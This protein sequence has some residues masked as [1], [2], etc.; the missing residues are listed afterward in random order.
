MEHRWGY[1]GEGDKKGEGLS[2]QTRKIR[3]REGTE[4]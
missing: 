4:T 2:R 1:G 3:G